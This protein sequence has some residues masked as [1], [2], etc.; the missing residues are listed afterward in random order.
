MKL[1]VRSM[2]DLAPNKLLNRTVWSS[3]QFDQ[4]TNTRNSCENCKYF[5]HPVIGVP[6]ESEAVRALRSYDRI[7]KHWMQMKRVMGQCTHLRIHAAFNKEVFMRCYE[8]CNYWELKE[9][10]NGM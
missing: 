1:D 7:K 3:P 4:G 2:D 9:K 5:Y 6:E 10:E 8:Y